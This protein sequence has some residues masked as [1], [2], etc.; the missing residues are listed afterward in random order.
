[1]KQ[2]QHHEGTSDNVKEQQKKEHE[3]KIRKQLKIST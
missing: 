2:Q 3:A 1:V